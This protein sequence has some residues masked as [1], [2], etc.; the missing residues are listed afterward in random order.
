MCVDLCP[1]DVF[2]Y[3]DQ[4]DV[5]V[6]ARQQDCIGC[7][8]CSYM[9]PSQCVDVGDVEMMRPFH[10]IP[11][12]VSLAERLLQAA[13]PGAVLTTEDH[14]EASSDVA[15]RLL[16]LADAIV[17]IMGRGY[18]PVG[19]RAGAAAAGATAAE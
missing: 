19:R 12:H 2:E 13:A 8:S 14:E 5:A 10:R 17:E 9:C 3:D 16:A 7:L 4:Q 11:S 1:V 6:V 15:A 18:K